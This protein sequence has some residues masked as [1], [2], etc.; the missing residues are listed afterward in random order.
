MGQ[1]Q[2]RQDGPG[3]PRRLRCLPV[4]RRR[5]HHARDLRPVRR[6]GPEGRHPRPR[7]AGRALLQKQWVKT[8]RAKMVLVTLGVFGASLFYGDGII[9]P[10]ISVLSAVEGLK[11]AT[12]GLAELV[13]PSCRSN[14]S[15]PSAPRW[16]WSPSASSVPP[17]STATASSRP[18]SPSCPPSRA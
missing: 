3:H 11:V 1:D 10:A 14:G 9:T 13:V 15:R 4:L 17:C 2:A 16:S 18:R 7:R 8:K 5:H 12:P 6:R